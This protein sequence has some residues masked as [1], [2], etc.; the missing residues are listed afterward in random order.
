MRGGG[1][2]ST[3]EK[4]G[5]LKL[6]C[7]RRC[8]GRLMAF[9]SWRWAVGGRVGLPPEEPPLELVRL[10]LRVVLELLVG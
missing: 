7:R 4:A 10:L 6:A 8:I 3:S 5:G 2:S 1:G 9:S